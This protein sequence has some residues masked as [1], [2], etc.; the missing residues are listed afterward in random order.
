MGFDLGTQ[1]FSLNLLLCILHTVVSLLHPVK[2]QSL[3]RV[4][5]MPQSSLDKSSHQYN[6]FLVITLE[7]AVFEL[8]TPMLGGGDFNH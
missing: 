7:T 5:T 6:F 1:P 8:S 4:S 2:Y 3:Q